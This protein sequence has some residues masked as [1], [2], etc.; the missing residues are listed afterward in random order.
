[1][2]TAILLCGKICCGK[3]TY[4]QKLSLKRNAV[5]LSCDE[6]TLCLSDFFP[7]EKHDDVLKNVK[8]YLQDQALNILS[9]GTNI[10][11]DYGFWTKPERISIRN[12]FQEKGFDV[13][14]HYLKISDDVLE[15]H[16]NSRN[17]SV[18][19]NKHLGYYVDNN[20]KLK[21]NNAFQEPTP[22]EVDVL[23]D[24]TE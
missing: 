23:I 5:V 8:S 14:L 9:V 10:I 11:L 21:M 22:N 15:H 1:M 16:I 7:P 6:L 13:E 18:L 2:A 3:S 20:L 17:I 24:V 4:S 19:K 12:Y